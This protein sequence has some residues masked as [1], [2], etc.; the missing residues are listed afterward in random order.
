MRISDWS[1]DVCSS[2]LLARPDVELRVSH[3]GKPSRR[4]KGDGLQPEQSHRAP[5][6]TLVGAVPGP[7]L[8][9]ELPIGRASCR[10]RVGQYVLISVGAG[11]LKKKKPQSTTTEQTHKLKDR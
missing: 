9:D 10:E 4:Y 2:D 3:N 8:L 5:G 11:S 1:S 7:L 6:V